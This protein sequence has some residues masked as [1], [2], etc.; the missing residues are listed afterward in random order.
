MALIL[1]YIGQQLAP[2]RS[3]DVVGYLGQLGTIIWIRAGTNLDLVAVC[4][5]VII[6]VSK[7]SL[8]VN[9]AI[10]ACDEHGVKFELVYQ[11]PL[12]VRCYCGKSIPDNDCQLFHATAYRLA[13]KLPDLLQ[14]K[15]AC[16]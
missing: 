4:N 16:R 9:Q 10:G 12:M 11:S 2:Q 13:R 8:L 14:L 6:N 1:G 3:D 7:H 5:A 15:L